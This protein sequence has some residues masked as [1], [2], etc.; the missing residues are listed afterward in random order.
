M[1][2]W[3]SFAL[4]ALL[5][6]LPARQLH[7][8]EL[9]KLPDAP[10]SDA[11]R[12]LLDQLR[13][14]PPPNWMQAAH[15]LSSDANRSV[16]EE[17]IKL[18]G[19]GEEDLRARAGFVLVD[20]KA[21][22]SLEQAVAIALTDRSASVRAR[23]AAGLLSGETPDL[24]EEAGLIEAVTKGLEDRNKDVRFSFAMILAAVGDRSGIPVLRKMLTH[25]DHHRRESAAE[26]LAGLGDDSGINVL[27]KM[28]SYTDKNHPFLKANKELK[29]N[30]ASWKNILQTVR[31]ER[32][33]VCGH[34]GRL[35][36][37]K[38]LKV[39]EKWAASDDADVSAAARKAADEIEAA[40]EPPGEKGDR[41]AP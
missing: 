25:S 32:M 12:N 14:T 13:N 10:L 4:V 34:L 17:L 5:L 18:A 35:K 22:E 3:T 23:I 39:L 28:L 30:A 40:Q 21:K 19:D 38:A 33:R 26:A 15:R 6:F 2:H 16:L 20:I 27:I 9:K 11:Q 37:R 24:L 8:G 29:K 1:K 41:E 31:E 36:N 7:A